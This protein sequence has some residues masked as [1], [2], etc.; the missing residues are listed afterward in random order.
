MRIV[1]CS[2]TH[3]FHRK[4]SIPDGDV[5]IHV[6]DF[7]MQA[8]VSH[9]KEFAEWVNALPH[10]KK[11]VVAGNHDIAASTMGKSWV[12][13]EFFPAFYLDH[14]FLQIG[15]VNFFGSP[16][17]SAIRDPSDWVF[18]YPRFGERGERLWNAILDVP[19]LDVLITHG[20][21]YS[22]GDRVLYSHVGEDPCVGDHTLYNV[23]RVKQPK[24]HL[25]G[26]IHEGY[27]R[28]EREVMFADLGWFEKRAA[29]QETVNK[30]VFYN[31][32]V[33]D[34]DYRPSNKVTVIDLPK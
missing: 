3:G 1:A 33:C 18:D 29:C 25:F 31:V 13:S 30:T 17:S 6:G 9:V 7:S 15:D 34:V 4:L 2:D 8:K 19:K 10:A 26:H 28:H 27:G 24:V 20:P 23:V 5:F 21:P 32:S 12:K 22:I 16:Y 11:I 14:E